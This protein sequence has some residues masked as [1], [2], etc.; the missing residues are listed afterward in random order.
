[1]RKNV[2]ILLFDE[3]EV[4]DFAGPF[5]VFGVTDALH[6][7][8]VF[9]TFTVAAEARPVRA[10]NGLSVNPAHAFAA[11]PPPHLLVI[12]GGQGTRPLLKNQPV[13]DWIKSAADRAELVLSVCTGSLLLAQCGLLDGLRATTHHNAISLLRTLAPRATI[14]EHER[15]TDNGRLLT[16]AGISAGLDLSLHVVARLLGPPAARRTAEQMEYREETA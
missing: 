8:T 13:L 10:R 1:M 7:H 12:P 5:E 11:C 6:D 4:L 14:V 2:A 3:V 16:S 15:F 9:N